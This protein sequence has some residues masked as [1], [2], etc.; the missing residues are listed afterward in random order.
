MYILALD[1]SLA[2]TGGSVF[3][4]NGNVIDVFSVP[5]SSKD[6]IQVR[7]KKIADFFE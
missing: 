6:L 4:E 2:N 7:L 1:I 3:D 5:T